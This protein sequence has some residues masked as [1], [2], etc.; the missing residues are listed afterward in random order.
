[1]LRTVAEAG[2]A[3]SILDKHQA[4]VWGIRGNRIQVSP[5]FIVLADGALLLDYRSDEFDHWHYEIAGI[6]VMSLIERGDA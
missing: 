4:V 1:M 2:V 6:P 3:L 5:D